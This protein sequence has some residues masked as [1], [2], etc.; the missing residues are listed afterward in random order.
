[1]SNPKPKTLNHFSIILLNLNPL[2]RPLTRPAGRP[3]TRAL[4]WR[5]A[6]ACF[7]ALDQLAQRVCGQIML[8]IKTH[9]AYFASGMQRKQK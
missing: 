3:L 8:N 2:T 6:R 9:H 1:M 4:V 7:R 5:Y